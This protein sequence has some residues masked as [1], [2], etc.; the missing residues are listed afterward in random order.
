LRIDGPHIFIRDPSRGG[1]VRDE[2][3]DRRVLREVE[4]LPLTW[5]HGG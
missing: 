4:N 2:L 1:D 5:S 3:G